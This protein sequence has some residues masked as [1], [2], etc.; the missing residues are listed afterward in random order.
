[1][2]TKISPVTIWLVFLGVPVVV[3]FGVSL[4]GF[5][6]SFTLGY[7]VSTCYAV[8]LLNKTLRLLESTAERVHELEQE[9]SNSN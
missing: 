9:Q 3:W 1:M 5:N 4:L 2:T 6:Y 7:L 8:Y